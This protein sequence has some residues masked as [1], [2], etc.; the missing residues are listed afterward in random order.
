[1]MMFKDMV[2][3]IAGYVTIE[4]FDRNGN[5]LDT[6]ENVVVDQGKGLLAD[7]LY[8]ADSSRLLDTLKLGNMNMTYGADISNL[9]APSS[10][11]TDLVNVIFTTTINTRTRTTING[12]AAVSHYFIVNPEDANDPNSNNYFNLITELGL[13]SHSGFMFSRLVQPI[14]KSRDIGFNLTWNILI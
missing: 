7:L 12:R 3:G 1:M 10:T 6:F 4:T 2:G 11:D 13:Y 5:I 9:P 14:I 8:N